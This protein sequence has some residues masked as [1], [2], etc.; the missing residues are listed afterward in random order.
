VVDRLTLAP[1]PFVPARVTVQPARPGSPLS[2]IPSPFRSLK[3][4][5]ETVAEPASLL[6]KSR[7]MIAWLDVSVKP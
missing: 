2:L 5:P 6:P 4:I 3:C 7:S 1:K